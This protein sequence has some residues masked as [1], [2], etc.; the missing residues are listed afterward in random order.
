M[1]AQQVEMH[2][3]KVPPPRG[4]ASCVTPGVWATKVP[5]PSFLEYAFSYTV[6]VPGG[7]IVVDLGWDSDEAW[8]AFELGL[9]RAGGRP[10]DVIG[11]VV[12]HTH[13]DHIGLLAR[14][15]KRTDVW[16]AG[17]VGEEANLL[18]TPELQGARLANLDTWLRQ[19]GVP[20]DRLVSMQQDALAINTHAHS[21]FDILLADQELVPHTG[22]TLRALHTPGHTPGHLCYFDEGRGLLFTGDHLLPRVTP[23]VS[24]RPGSNSDPLAD[25]ER[26]LGKVA[27]LGDHVL[28]LPG[29]EWPFERPS[30][31]AAEIRAHSRA[32]ST[33]MLSL[34]DARPSTVW[35]LTTSLLWS[36]PFET[37]NVRGQRQALGET[38]AHLEH[39]AAQGLVTTQ[40]EKP[41]RWRRPVLSEPLAQVAP[42]T[43]PY[44][45]T[46]NQLKEKA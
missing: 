1:A 40:G 27:A 14:L 10:E 33:E 46:E 32:R 37:L 30:D 41:Q 26:S 8:A 28:V 25:Y 44:C 9:S 24:K 3:K 35:S 42:P 21:T 20:A 29:H 2:A 4:V 45:P 39:L 11:V 17:H 18:S 23:N 12:T 7:F 43:P 19:C 38:H 22:G 13:P 31:R 5:F 36:R 34:L 16:V 15:R 6:R